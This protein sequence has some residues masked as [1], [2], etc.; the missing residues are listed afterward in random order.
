VNSSN[1]GSLR[2]ASRAILSLS[3]AC[4]P[5]SESSNDACMPFDWG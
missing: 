5:P 4:S 2:K 3:I 1:R